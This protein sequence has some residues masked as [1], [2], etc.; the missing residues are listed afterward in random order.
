MIRSTIAKTLP[1]LAL[2]LL[3]SNS[4]SAL[5]VLDGVD[6]QVLLAKISAKE[7]TRIAISNGRIKQFVGNEGDLVIQKDTS[8]G[9]IFVHPASMTGKPVNLFV[10][11]DKGATYT[12][13]LQPV[14][15]PAETILLRDKQAQMNTLSQV[16]RAGSYD[17]VLKGMVLVMATDD[18]PPDVE[19]K[20]V[21]RDIALWREARFTQ[22]KTYLGRDLVGEKYRLTNV[23]AKPMVIA[24]QELYRKGVLAVSVEK[25]SLDPNE[26][27]NVFIVRERGRNE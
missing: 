24:E 10:T 12:L 6:G 26:S 11:D 9:Q 21:D 5:Q 2:L 22:L 20:D 13:L 3:A 15:I 18:V 17:R 8:N 23:S 19:V 4:A 7:P 16:E 14:D 25:T 27:T 1:L